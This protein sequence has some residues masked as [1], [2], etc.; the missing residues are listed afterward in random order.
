MR[1]AA[2]FEEKRMLHT[3]RC[4]VEHDAVVAEE[5]AER[6]AP[7][8]AAR[9]HIENRDVRT[10]ELCDDDHVLPLCSWQKDV[11]ET[12]E[13]QKRDRDDRH[14]I[15]VVDPVGHSGKSYFMRYMTTF[16]G[17]IRLPSTLAS[18]TA[19]MQ[20]LCSSAK[21]KED[22]THTIMMDVPRAISKKHWWAM[23]QGL[24]AIKQGFLYDTRYSGKEKVIEP[25]IVIAFSNYEPPEGILS[26][27]VFVIIKL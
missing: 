22:Y 17:A 2:R 13:Q 20:F 27:D 4:M 11:L 23:A 7:E 15:L 16:K 12:I 1:A 6:E 9:D 24:D 18:A 3:L 25:P 14:I 5:E 19:A 26:E 10:A 21:L 8:K